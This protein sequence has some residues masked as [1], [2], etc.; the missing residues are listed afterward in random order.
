MLTTLRRLLTTVF[1]MLRERWADANRVPS[2]PRS[3]V[4]WVEM[5]DDEHG[6]ALTAATVT[7]TPLGGRPPTVIRTRVCPPVADDPSVRRLPV[8]PQQTQQTRH[9]LE[10]PTRPQAASGPPGGHGAGKVA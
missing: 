5:G 2:P 6:D 3:N 7:Y 9:G 1:A 10:T 8:M 4:A